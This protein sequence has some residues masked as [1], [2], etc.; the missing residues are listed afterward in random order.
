MASCMSPIGVTI[1]SQSYKK[2]GTEAVKRFEKHVGIAVKV[3]ECDDSEGFASKLELDRICGKRDIIFFDADL[4][5]LDRPNLEKAL[6]HPCLTAVHDSAAF[7]PHAFPHTD[8]ERFGMPKTEYFNSGL[9]MLSFKNPKHVQMFSEA[10]RIFRRLKNKKPRLKPVDTTDQFYLNKARLEVGLSWN[11]LPT[12]FNY[13]LR[14]SQWGQLP[15]IPRK[16]IGL[17]GAGIKPKEKFSKMTLQAKVFEYPVCPMHHE[18][19]AFM[20]ALQHDLR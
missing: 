10:R 17:H 7:N 16:I 3:H 2:V 18:T 5:F 15:S 9:M 4:W 19:L 13:Y 12:A 20:H 11:R 6:G 8:C 1:I 14:A